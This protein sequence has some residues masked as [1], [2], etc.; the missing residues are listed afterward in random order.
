[1]HITADGT[2]L[3]GFGVW[4]LAKFGQEPEIEC[5]E[6]SFDEEQSVQFILLHHQPRRG[7]NAF[8]RI[9]VALS[10]ERLLQDRALENQRLGGKYKGS[11]K[12]PKAQHLDIRE[13]IARRAGVG[14]RN[15]TVVKT[16]LRSAHPKLIEA[17]AGGLLTIHRAARLSNLSKSEQLKEFTAQTTNRVID[18]VIRHSITELFKADSKS[19]T[20]ALLG[21]LSQIEK[22]H[23]GSVVVRLTA[24][25][26][27]TVLLGQDIMNLENVASEKP[28][29]S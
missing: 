7:W 17:L 28:Q 13:Q 2:I 24:R 4:R 12:L 19:E 8:N 10:L 26:R 20:A 6:Y 14:A 9:R 27:T 18:N 22:Q 21:K 3:A 1:M 15:V 5:V 25:R 16:I 29:P 23:P 11:A